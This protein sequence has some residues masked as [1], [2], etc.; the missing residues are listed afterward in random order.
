MIWFR[1][2]SKRWCFKVKCKGYIAFDLYWTSVP[3]GRFRTSEMISHLM[4]T[5]SSCLAGHWHPLNYSQIK[6]KEKK[7]LPRL[8]N[9]PVE[10]DTWIL[11]G[12]VVN[13]AARQWLNLSRETSGQQ[14]DQ[15]KGAVGRSRLALSI[16]I[17]RLRTDESPCVD[18][19]I[20]AR[21]TRPSD[22]TA[23]GNLKNE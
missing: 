2:I 6:K 22:V 20:L 23:S 3:L 7:T 1:R 13:A 14:V 17:E 5:C 15:P 12:E 4:A 16:E 10:W 8:V 19:L 9:E 18:P 11:M 21:W